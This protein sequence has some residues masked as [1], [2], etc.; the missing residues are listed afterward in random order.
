MRGL[1][2]R[3]RRRLFIRGW[4]VA[5]LVRPRARTEER[6]F[7]LKARVPSRNRCN[8]PSHKRSIDLIEYGR[9]FAPRGSARPTRIPALARN[10]FMD[11]EAAQRRLYYWLDILTSTKELAQ[12]YI[13]LELFTHAAPRMQLLEY[14]FS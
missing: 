13:S 4:S 10:A 9:Q 6:F 7:I 12:I 8:T 3:N 5:A 1:Y 14:T 2:V 11:G